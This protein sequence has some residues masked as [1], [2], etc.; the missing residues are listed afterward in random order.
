MV[1]AVFAVKI[2][3]SH[4][5]PL[6]TQ[7]IEEQPQSPLAPT[8]I[9]ESTEEQPQPPLAPSPLAPMPITESTEEQPQSPLVP[10]PL[11]PTPITE[12]TEEQPQPPLAPTRK[13]SR[14]D[15]PITESTEEQPRPPRLVIE[16]CV[17]WNVRTRTQTSPPT[18]PMSVVLRFE[19]TCISLV[20]RVA[21]VPD[22]SYGRAR[23]TWCD[24]VLNDTQVIEHFR[25]GPWKLDY[26]KTRPPRLL[27]SLPPGSTLRDDSRFKCFK[28]SCSVC[29][30]RGL[31]FSDL[32][33]EMQIKCPR[34][35][36]PPEVVNSDQ[37]RGEYKKMRWGES[38]NDF[39]VSYQSCKRC[40][41]KAYL[42]ERHGKL[43]E[44]RECTKC[45]ESFRCD[46]RTE[47]KPFFT[48]V[49][50]A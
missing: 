21:V 36:S 42:V 44:K 39:F 26:N 43:H 37:K 46:D 41:V 4:K 25:T 1:T 14:E 49:T 24:E 10:Y 6:I 19:E 27:L 23:L 12:S 11:A 32:S 13:R 47:T 20:S 16:L 2:K 22:G 8:P 9:T 48:I 3:R 28:H 17:A 29:A 35:D 5:D 33:G 7:S 31:V 45:G 18:P 50:N 38:A 30:F 15:P 40:G 34:C